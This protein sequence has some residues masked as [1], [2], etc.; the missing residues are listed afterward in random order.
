MDE[1]FGRDNFVSVISFAKTS[2]FESKVLSRAGDYLL[3]YARRIE[4]VKYHQLYWNKGEDTSGYNKTKDGKLYSSG[5]LFSPGI[6]ADGSKPFEFK[7][8]KFYPSGGHWKTSERGLKRLVEADR[9]ELVGTTLRYIRFW[10]DFN[11][12]PLNN[13]WEDTQTFTE[14]LYAVQTN[15]KVVERCILM[16]TDPGDLVFDPTCGSGTTAYCAEKWGRRWITCDTSRVALAIARQRLMTA[17]FDYYELLDPER[18]PAGGFKYETVPHITLESIAK[19]TEIDVIAANYQPEIDKALADLNRAVGENWQEWEVPREINKNWN[20]KAQEAHQRF[21]N[22]KRAKRQEIDR[23]IQ[24]NAPQETLY[25][26]PFTKRGVV[27]VSGPFTVEALPPPAIS[28]PEATPIPQYEAEEGRVDNRASDYILRMINL[29]KQQGGVIFP[30]GK[31]LELKDIRRAALGFVHAEAE[32]QI[33]GTPK[34]VAISFGPEFGPVT[35]SQVR[36]AIDPATLNKFDILLVAGGSFEPDVH[37]FASKAP[38]KIKDS[39]LTI[40]CVNIAPDVLSGDLLKTNRASQIF[41]VFGEPDVAI[42][43]KADGTFIAELKGVRGHFR[44]SRVN[45][46]GLRSSLLTSVETR[47][48]GCWS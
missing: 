24:R 3:W 19:N 44:L 10:N 7:G 47:W 22:L 30:G 32:A 31:R 27:R 43:P 5:A 15:T 34:R 38:E 36:E 39:G 23:S 8:R 29:L 28:I 33:E 9:I 20:K 1:V 2:G 13:I 14:K 6:T 35:A 25:D 37:S 48:C 4:E 46:N 16:T 45:S 12:V 11:L 18:G 21:W 42:E 17:K 40:Q 41:T 26:R